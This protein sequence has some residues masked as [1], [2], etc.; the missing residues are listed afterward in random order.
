MLVALLERWSA[1]NR[2]SKHPPNTW[3][4]YAYSTTHRRQRP[5]PLPAVAQYLR[6]VF[7]TSFS[8]NSRETT[9]LN[10]IS[11]TNWIIRFMHR[12][13]RQSSDSI[14]HKIFSYFPFNPNVYHRSLL[15]HRYD[16]IDV[17]TSRDVR[18][19]Y[20]TIRDAILT[21][22]RKP[23]WVGLIYRTKTTTKNCK[24]KTKNSLC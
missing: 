19:Q 10:S 1:D 23:T 13:L 7:P 5:R 21:C 16:D 20:I 14:S 12:T 15:S 24:Q 6:D 17:L 2:R 11:K 9:V 4:V 18:T 3:T 22:A 8:N